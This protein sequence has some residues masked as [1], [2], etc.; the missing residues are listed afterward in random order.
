MLLCAISSYYVAYIDYDK[1]GMLSKSFKNIQVQGQIK[2]WK[3]S[4]YLIIYLAKYLTS[5]RGQLKELIQLYVDLAWYIAL[6]N[7][8]HVVK[9]F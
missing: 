6:W 9:E 2:F 7:K 5:S 3:E 1:G 4:C 8:S